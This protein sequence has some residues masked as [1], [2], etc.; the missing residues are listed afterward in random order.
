M[1]EFEKVIGY[2]AIKNELRQVSD[3]LQHPDVYRKMGAKLPKGIL[4]FGAPG[5]GKTLMANCFLESCKVPY[6]VLRK[7]KTAEAFLCEIDDVFQKA[8]E[9]TPSVV[10]LDDLDKFANSDF[11]HRD[12]EE[13][14]AVQAA[15]DQ[16]K[17]Y[18]ILV[19]AT[20]NDMRKL[21]DSLVRS[22]RFD[23]RIEFESPTEADTV[24]II[25]HYLKGKPVSENVNLDDLSKMIHYHSCADLETLLNEAASLAAFRRKDSIEMDDMI[26]TVLRMEYDVTDSLS[27]KTDEEIRKTAFHEAGHLVVSEVLLPG[28]VGFASV[29]RADNGRA[30][31]FVHRCKKLP[32]SSSAILVSLSG[33]AA[34]ELYFAETCAEGCHSDLERA[35]NIIRDGI[36]EAGTCGIGMLDVANERFPGTSE[37]LNARN[38]AVVHAELERFLFKTRDILLKNREFLEKTANELAEKE[39]LLASDIRRI[40]ESVS[41]IPAAV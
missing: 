22:G 29:N 38:E 18:D 8:A 21:P 39:Y 10:F 16:A 35:F 14:V 41:V 15:I 17:R 7:N 23:R 36:S 19:L 5:L 33:K 34:A 6:Y 1:K 20:V 9:H 4:L 2:D 24:E 28:S 12:A 40:R 11:R 27:R 26:Q 13:Y 31:G 3:M 25:R 30:G 32:D 37:S